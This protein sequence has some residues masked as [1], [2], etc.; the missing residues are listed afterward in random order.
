MKIINADWELRNLGVTTV[1][2]EIED[3]DSIE[4]VEKELENISAKYVVVKLPSYKTDF[5][6][7]IQRLGY[8]YIEDM[9]HLVSYLNEVNFSPIQKRFNA[10]IAT[11]VMNTV[12][13]EN[14]KD[15]I[16]NGLFSTDRIYLDSYFTEEQAYNRYINWVTDEYNRGTQFIKYIYKE[17]TVGFFALKDQGEGRYT[18]FLGGIYPEFRK[19]GI[20]TTVKVPQVVKEYGGKSVSTSVSSNNPAQIRNLIMNGFLPEGITHTFI[21]HLD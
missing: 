11:Q 3:E 17:N 15:Q 14:L 4:I 13:V 2:I 5:L 1:E 8:T 9:V 18:S 16:R 21:K 19:G 7:I 6:F 12:D 20:G 10:S